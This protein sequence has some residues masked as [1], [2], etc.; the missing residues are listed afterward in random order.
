MEEKSKT[1][2][3]VEAI[4]NAI[5]SLENLKN[6]IK[7]DPDANI[8][9]ISIAANEKTAKAAGT[10]YGS[11]VEIASSLANAWEETDKGAGCLKMALM[12]MTLED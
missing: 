11:S 1:Q 8:S 6:E 10:I 12:M 9:V 7:D 4:D 2:E 3:A 5:K